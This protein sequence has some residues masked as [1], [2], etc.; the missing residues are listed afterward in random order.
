MQGCALTI[1]QF[2]YLMNL[3]EIVMLLICNIYEEGRTVGIKL[4]DY[5]SNDKMHIINYL[6]IKLRE[7]AAIGGGCIK[8]RAFM[9][10]FHNRRDNFACDFCNGKIKMSYHNTEIC[11]YNSER[12]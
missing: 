11:I 12:S 4:L 6:R 10:L 8:T 1:V 7:Q 2:V 5:M 3:L 9:K